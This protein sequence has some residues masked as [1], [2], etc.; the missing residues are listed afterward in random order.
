MAVFEGE[1][2]EAVRAAT[3]NVKASGHALSPSVSVISAIFSPPEEIAMAVELA[4]VRALLSRC[5]WEIRK[6]A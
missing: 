4:S 3:D 5:P 1:G 6:H 2:G